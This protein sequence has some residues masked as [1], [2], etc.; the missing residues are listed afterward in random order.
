MIIMSRLVV[1]ELWVSEL[2]EAH[3]LDPLLY[4]GWR[5]ACVTQEATVVL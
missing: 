5:K 3:T 4:S 2:A 1:A